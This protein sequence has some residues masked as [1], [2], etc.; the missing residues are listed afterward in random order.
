MITTTNSIS[1]DNI[2]ISKLSNRDIVSAKHTIDIEIDALR[3]MESELDSSLTSALDI[4]QSAKGRVILTGMGKS[5]HI[6]K[7]IAASLASTGTPS[8]FVHPAEASHGDLGMI[9]NNDVIIAISNSGESKELID[10]LNYSKRFGIKLIA[11]TK[12]PESSLGKAGD[13]V[14]KLPSAKEAC[15]LD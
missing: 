1:N 14:L 3:V 8:F 9:T 12:N 5:G 11:I 4:M 6:A 10:I 2:N 15:P 13:V 7:K